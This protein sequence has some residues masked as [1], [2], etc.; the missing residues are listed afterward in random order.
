M[1]GRLCLT[2]T[3]TIGKKR[4]FEVKHSMYYSITLIQVACLLAVCM[5]YIKNKNTK[6]KTGRPTVDSL[7]C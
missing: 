1:Q 5:Q 2:V 4:S 7:T 6:F 3:G